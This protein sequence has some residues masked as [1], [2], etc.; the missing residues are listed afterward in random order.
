ML[1]R[2][3]RYLQQTHRNV[4]NNVSPTAA[5]EQSIITNVRDSNDNIENLGY[6]QRTLVHPKSYS[7]YKNNVGFHGSKT[8]IYI[9]LKIPGLD[10]KL[11][12]LL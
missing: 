11:D 9:L 5:V 1:K 7:S 2:S 8:T 10:L 6:L 3:T 12:V 4:L